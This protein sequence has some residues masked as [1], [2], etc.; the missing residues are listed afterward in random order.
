M[1][2]ATLSRGIATA[3]VCICSCPYTLFLHTPVLLQYHSPLSF[4][5]ILILSFHIMQGP[6]IFSHSILPYSCRLFVISISLQMIKPLQGVALDHQ[7]LSIICFSTF[8]RN[9]EP[10]IHTFSFFSPSILFMAD[11]S[12]MSAA[13]IL[14]LCHSPHVNVSLPY[15]SINTFTLSRNLPFSLP[16][17]FIFPC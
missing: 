17:L 8:T 15:V 4:S 7:Q 11:L 10:P 2:L 1:F 13:W 5:N 3:D 6:K 16:F 9:T 12:L 14:H